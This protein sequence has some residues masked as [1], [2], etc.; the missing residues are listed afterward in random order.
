MM[1]Q[2]SSGQPK[3]SFG[4]I[5][6]ETVSVSA[7]RNF[8]VLSISAERASFGRNGIIRQKYILSEVIVLQKYLLCFIM[9]GS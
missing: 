4:G 2:K 5:S 9:G 8:P 6:A 3:G 1:G 7:E